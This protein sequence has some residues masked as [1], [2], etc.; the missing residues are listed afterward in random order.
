MI[1]KTKISL[2]LALLVG[3]CASNNDREDSD[4]GVPEDSGVPDSSTD[5]EVDSGTDAEVDSGTDSGTEEDG[6]VCGEVVVKSTPVVPNVVVIVDQSGSM[7]DPFGAQSRWQTLKDYLLGADGLI[8]TYQSRVNFGLALF[9]GTG[10]SGETCPYVTQVPAGLSNFAAISAVYGPAE[11]L[12]NTPTG[13]SITKVITD[14]EPSANQ[15]VFILATDGEPDTC[16]Q[17]WPQEGQQ[18]AI[19]AVKYAY[20]LGII[21]YVVA[22]ANEAELSQEHVSNMANA[23]QGVA[24]GAESY[25]VNT[26]AEVKS[27]LNQI[28]SGAISC[29]VPI[30]GEV[31]ID[32]PCLGTVKLNGTSLACGSTDGWA[33]Q[34]RSVVLTGT[35][36]D[37]FK[38]GGE[39]TASFP[40]GTQ[41]VF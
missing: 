8:Q 12:N 17:P 20:S 23:G 30:N 38:L 5:A 7:K 27:A 4:S 15:T 26:G 28:V 1:M 24:S 32:D 6:G 41:I 37:A 19:D 22:V 3:A 31:T 35:A 33:L 16:E 39:L 14:L 21:T 34:G 2:V 10:P 29:T 40:C 9:S 36:C 25:R 18:E 11:P 13:D